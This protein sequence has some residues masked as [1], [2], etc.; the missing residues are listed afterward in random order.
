MRVL[1]PAK[2]GLTAFDGDMRL[3]PALAEYKG[4]T[5]YRDTVVGWLSRYDDGAATTPGMPPE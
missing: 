4:L 1:V 3:H 2:Q 5:R